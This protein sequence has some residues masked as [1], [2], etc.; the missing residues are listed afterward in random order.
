MWTGVLGK[1]Y[2]LKA[3]EN[4]DGLAN[5]SCSGCSMIF[6]LDVKWNPVLHLCS[7]WMADAIFFSEYQELLDG[8]RINIL[9]ISIFSRS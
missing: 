9:E 8:F 2:S 3:Y 4:V 5:I 6:F 1:R 7:F